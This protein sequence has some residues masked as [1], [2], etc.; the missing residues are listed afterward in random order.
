MDGLNKE[1]DKCC[2]KRKERGAVVQKRRNK[3]G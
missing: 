1:R 2:R 3:C